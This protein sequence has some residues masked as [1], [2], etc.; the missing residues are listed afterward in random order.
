[1]NVF[2]TLREIGKRME[3]AEDLEITLENIEFPEELK[4]VKLILSSLKEY[5]S[6]V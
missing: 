3:V 5:K 6:D 4:A 1:M 2:E